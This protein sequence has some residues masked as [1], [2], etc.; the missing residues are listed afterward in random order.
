M[1][2]NQE[3]IKY[4]GIDYGKKRIGLAVSDDQGRLAF[5]K[6]VLKNDFELIP[7]IKSLIESE[8]IDKIVLG[9]S[10]NYSMDPNPIMEEIRNF[11][12]KIENITDKPIFFE[13]EYLSSAEASRVQ[14]QNLMNDAS[15][16]AIILQRFL[17]KIK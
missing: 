7:Y 15:A 4:L 13:P 14:G 9:E 6:A 2:K 5:P 3:R 8:K 12:I 17:D 1:P 11:R 16:A 10:L